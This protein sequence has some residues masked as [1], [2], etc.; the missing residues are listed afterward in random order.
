[1]DKDLMLTV[2]KSGNTSK[3]IWDHLQR[4]FQDN[5]GSRAATLEGKFVNLKFIDCNDVDDYC[6]KLKALA[7]RL[8]DLDFPMNDK[9]L[10]DRTATLLPTPVIPMRPSPGPPTAYSPNW[11]PHWNSSSTSHSPNWAPHWNA[12]PSPFPTVPSWASQQHPSLRGRGR[13]SRGRGSGVDAAHEQPVHR[14][15]MLLPPRNIYN[16]RI[17]PKHTAP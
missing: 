7:N 15:R 13:Q 3:E 8:S 2:L 6:D 5:K 11:A 17:L 16:Q 10:L 9:R 1:M 12:P 14:K 4:L